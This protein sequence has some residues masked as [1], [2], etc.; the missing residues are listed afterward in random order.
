M[1]EYFDTDE[2]AL[3]EVQRGRAWG[4]LVFSSNYSE[5]L[6][7]RTESGRYADD[8]TIESSDIDI[9]LDLSS[10]CI[11]HISYHAIDILFFSTV[12]FLSQL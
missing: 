3:I 9:K 11:S 12:S 1:Q 6:V 10:E 2:A 4:S 8:F 5:A 7:E